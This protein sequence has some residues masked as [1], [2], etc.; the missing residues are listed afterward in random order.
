MYG[1]LEKF[2]ELR[3]FVGDFR[4]RMERYYG[5]R[6]QLLQGHDSL[7]DF[8]NAHAWYGFHKTIEGWVY[9]EWA[10]ATDG[11]YLTG[12]FNGWD[13][14]AT[15]LTRLADGNWEIKFPGEVLKKGRRVLTIVKN[16]DQLT[17]HIPLYARRVTQDWVTQSWCCEVW[18]EETPYR[19][20]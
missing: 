5:K 3:P 20:R 17:Q 8:A 16:G 12:D 6:E 9:R 1:I 14:T 7:E 13:W 11:V 18:D 10:P 2:P 15:P 19:S 4:L